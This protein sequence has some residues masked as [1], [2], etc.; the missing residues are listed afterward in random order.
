MKTPII[1]AFYIL[2]FSHLFSQNIGADS[3]SRKKITAIPV[4]Q[5][6]KIDGILDE[7]IWK[8]A[9]SAGNFIERRPNNGKPAD[10]SFRS[11]VKILYDD[12]GIYFG[13]IL[14]D[15]EPGKIAKE[16]TERDNIENDDIFGVTLNGY[17]DHQQ[18]LE[19]LITPAGVQ[20]DAKLTTDFG[21]DFSWNA[22]WFSA[23]QIT[24]NGWVV[25]MKIPY[26]E[27]RFP[28][29]QIQEWGINILRL[30]NRTSTTY[31]WNFV[32]NKKG[33]YML[34]DG[35]L[36]GIENINPPTR[37]S[38]L[39][40]FSTY[41]NHF[42]GKTTTNF[43]GGMDLKYGINDAFTL[44]LTLIP[45]FGQTS[46]DKSVLN[47][48]PFEVQFQEQRPFF[49]EGTELFSKGNLFYSRR[50]GG[51]PSV[52]PILNEDEIFVENPDK[53]KLFN[54]VKIS[55]RTNK[56][57]GIGFFNAVT[58]KM[59]AEIRNINTGATRTEVTE[60]WANYSVFVLDQRFQGNS[61]VSLVNSNVT[62][63][64][65]F[66][67]ANVTAL[68]FD[69]R[70]KKNT[71]RYFGGTKASFVLN[72]GTKAGNES[73]AG[74]NKVSGTH[75]FGAN[76]F[77][78]T[79]DYDIGD[80]GYYDRTNFH[81][82]NTNYSYRY[83][84]PKGGL[85]ALN[86]NLNVSH[87]RRLDE[88]LFTQFVIH[89]S[90]EMQTKKFFNFGGGLM[91]WP[92]GEN[93]IYEPRTAGRF[94][95]VPAMINPWIFINTD[96]RRKFR[97][98]TYID[99]YAYDEK[100]RYQLIYQLN[101]SYKFSDKLRLY[102]DANFNYQNND[103]GFVGKNSS[104]IF[105]GNRNRFTVENGISSQYTFNNKMALNLSFR[106]YF[107]QVTYKG[108]S[109]LNANGSV[110]DTSLFTENRDGTFN[111]WNV[112][113]RYSWWFAPGSQ[114][115]L[116][117]R[118]AVGSYLEESGIGIKENFNRLFNE[119]MVDNI[120]LKLTYYIDYNQAKNWLKKKG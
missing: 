59:T 53:V 111:S 67:D 2:C 49:T 37:L 98:N 102:Y 58:E 4:T 22:V 30:V 63:D 51:N 64:G 36:E 40:Y 105:M 20:A 103:R 41:L 47:L 33:S 25:E 16:L 94:L 29:K 34:Y 120:S 28:K 81:S 56:G 112:D 54:A 113:L 38:F 82:I 78:R 55:G 92:I 83:L 110:T 119:P 76:Y 7:E 118:N 11:E 24:E 62:R 107:S 35:L 46:F 5:S 89:N 27:L 79:K 21:E 75:R 66:R 71:Y 115:T 8:N 26:S 17:N 31:D 6:P 101:P 74:F 100:G 97:I 109:T 72:G 48:S 61:S 93:D 14:F 87:N 96:N 104:E 45:D 114:L 88:D 12:T 39:P 77:M 108:F 10:E 42:Q 80:L 70:N 52:S 57:L 73:T 95:K 9:T 60:P 44:D 86:Y 99:Y 65:S 3:I 84:Q 23:V 69:I 50:I 85:N 32:D 90:I 18:S 68:L 19:F 91:I 15:T 13:A 1:S 106:H 43:N 116:L 117:Y